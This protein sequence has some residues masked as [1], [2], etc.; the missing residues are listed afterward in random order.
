[1]AQYCPT[2]DSLKNEQQRIEKELQSFESSLWS[3][4]ARESKATDE[5]TSS[6]PDNATKVGSKEAD[7]ARAR[8]SQAKEKRAPKRAK[9]PKQKKNNAVKSSSSGGRSARSRF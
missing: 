7:T 3:R 8:R 2:P 1:M 4:A 6:V 9:A 5:M